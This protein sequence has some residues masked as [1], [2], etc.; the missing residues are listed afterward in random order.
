M[1]PLLTRSHEV[2]ALLVV[3]VEASGEHVHLLQAIQKDEQLTRGEVAEHPPV[4]IGREGQW[5]A[6]RHHLCACVSVYHKQ[7]GNTRM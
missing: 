4:G 1:S 3:A 6:D 7:T 2:D 5:V